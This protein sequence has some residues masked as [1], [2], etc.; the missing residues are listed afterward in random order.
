[1]SDWAK[2]TTRWFVVEDGPGIVK[3]VN[4]KAMLEALAQLGRSAGM[5]M[6]RLPDGTTCYLA[7]PCGCVHAD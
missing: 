5:C 2:S 6:K 1:M 7:T 3:S 4:R